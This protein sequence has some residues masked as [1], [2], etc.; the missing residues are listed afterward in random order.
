MK[1]LLKSRRFI[2]LILSS[3]FLLASAFS[4]AMLLT[5]QTSSSAHAS[6]IT[7]ASPAYVANVL[8]RTSPAAISKKLDFDHTSAS[9]YTGVKGN[10]WGFDF[11][12]GKRIY[13]PPV[14]FCG[15]YFSCTSNFWQEHGYVT[16]CKDG[17]YSKSGG[18][19]DNCSV[20]GGVLRTLYSHS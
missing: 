18:D 2:T 7:D 1:K 16:E 19:R 3:L 6:G 13:T 17:R 20:Y 5:H 15:Y 4:V 8:T 12:A 14:D 10:P 9:H 11:N